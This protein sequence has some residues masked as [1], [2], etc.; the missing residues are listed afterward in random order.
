MDEART[1]DGAA[2]Q[3]A[4]V[5]N[6]MAAVD[7]KLDAAEG[8]QPLHGEA[9]AEAAPA[10]DRGAELGAMLT[11][12]VKVVSPALP[13]LPDCYTPEVCEKIGHAFAAVADKHGWNLGGMDSPE[14]ALA[15]VSVPPTL[16][17][18]KLGRDHF[19]VKRM[20]AEAMAD[21]A[22]RGQV[23]DAGHSGQLSV[24]QTSGHAG[25]VLQPGGA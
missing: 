16:A 15:L 10:V 24:V 8:L 20:E 14:V 13:F 12:G 3:L 17:A 2:T 25:T 6:S 21:A 4:A 1:E 9:Q 11:L 19:A 5:A 7:S 22:R 18:I 23:I